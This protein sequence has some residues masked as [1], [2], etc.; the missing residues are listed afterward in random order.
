MGAPGGVLRAAGGGDDLQALPQVRDG[1]GELP[2]AQSRRRPGVQ[3]VGQ[4]C[5]VPAH[6]LA[7]HRLLAQA[8]RL[9]RIGL[10]TGHACGER[11][12][13]PTWRPA[14]GSPQEAGEQRTGGRGL[15]LLVVHTRQLQGQP[16]PYGVAVAGAAGQH[17]G[18]V[19]P[20]H[21][22]RAAGL[23][24]EH[25]PAAPPGEL[26][27][28]RERAAQ[29]GVQ[30]AGCAQTLQG[31]DA[32]GTQ[33]PETR[34]RSLSGQTDDE[35]LG[36]QGAQDAEDLPPGYA[37]T[38]ADCLR[39]GRV[40][41][42]DQDRKT[43]EDRLLGRIQ[44]PVAPVDRCGEPAVACRPGSAAP[45]Q[46]VQ[47]RELVFQPGQDVAQRERADVAGHEFDG[48]RQAVEA[49]ADLG[50]QMAV[51][52]MERESRGV[53]RGAVDEEPYRLGPQEGCH[54]VSGVGRRQGQLA[55]PE[56]GLSGHPQRLPAGGQDP[57]PGAPDQQGRR[58]PGAR[59]RQML[60]VVQNQHP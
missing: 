26:G 40:E 29:G 14:P 25:L 54:I 47:L 30:L 21:R 51:A 24:G 49:P 44:Q 32:D 3:G 33:L 1:L 42:A 37:V 20:L 2:A 41:P 38:G 46:Q 56:H 58:E 39:G 8:Q 35:R 13:L 10:L 4:S 31:A 57:Q 5:G 6:P 34:G 18:E 15:L 16:R 7:P 45:G 43:P 27:Q 11:G 28:P 52:A 59:L 9:V 12:H 53:A 22:E 50:H 17:R 48:E 23:V 36:F 19:V 60:A 55:D